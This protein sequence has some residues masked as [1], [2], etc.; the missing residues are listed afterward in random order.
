MGMR[1]D[2]VYQDTVKRMEP[3]Q[4]IKEKGM[5]VWK[6]TRYLDGDGP[7]DDNEAVF[8]GNPLENSAG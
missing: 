4:C 8:D 2:D 6:D 3:N 1:M 5:R 7:D